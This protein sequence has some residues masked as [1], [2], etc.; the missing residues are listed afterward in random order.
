MRRG[1]VDRINDL[2]LDTVVLEDL[3]CRFFTGRAKNKSPGGTGGGIKVHPR[4]WARAQMDYVW[5]W[6]VAA[7]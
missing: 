3:Q 1:C 7:K 5:S 4:C 6:L 2:N